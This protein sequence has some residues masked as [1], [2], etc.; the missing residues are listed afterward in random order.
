MLDHHLFLSHKPNLSRYHASASAALLFKSLSLRCAQGGRRRYTSL[1][2]AETA[3]F[4]SPKST[5]RSAIPVVN[6]TVTPFGNSS[7]SETGKPPSSGQS[8]SGFSQGGNYAPLPG[9]GLSAGY[10][11]AP[12]GSLQ[13]PNVVYQ[14]IQD[15][16]SKRIS[17]LEYLRK[18]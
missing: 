3:P 13:N 8:S 16:S 6:M 7:R 14:H 5:P 9:S 1:S 2:S 12:P 4:F 17:T 10:V 11:N 18:A 15:L